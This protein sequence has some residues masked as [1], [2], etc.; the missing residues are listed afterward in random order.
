MRKRFG[1][2]VLAAILSLTLGQSAT[3]QGTVEFLVDGPKVAS[4]AHNFARFSAKD[5]YYLTS[6]WSSAAERTPSSM[7]RKTKA[8]R[9]RTAYQ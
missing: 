7:P 6:R 3:A 9:G 2:G 8:W 1:A 4:T 5:D